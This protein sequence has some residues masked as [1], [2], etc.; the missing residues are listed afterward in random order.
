MTFQKGNTYWKLNLGRKFTEEHKLKLSLASIGKKNHLGHKHSNETKKKLSEFHKGKHHS[1]ET[2]LKI[3]LANK[4]KKHT[5]ETKRKIGNAQLKENNHN[6][7][8]GRRK[9][10]RGYI[11]ILKP[12]H[13]FAILKGYVMEHRLVMEE[14]IGR[15][16]KPKEVV[17]HENG[18]KDDNR[19]ENL[20]LFTNQ[21]EHL[22]YH[23]QLL[24]ENIWQVQNRSLKIFINGPQ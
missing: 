23:K 11:Y 8:N 22:K 4:G 19:L 12:E 15:Y 5:E 6:W 17:H 18:I 24:E 13:P 16:L 14:A 1:E 10:K 21:K 9:C 20:L 2:K 3:S 7:K